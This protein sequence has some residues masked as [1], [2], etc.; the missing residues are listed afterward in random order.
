[1]NSELYNL[2]KAHKVNNIELHQINKTYIACVYSK[3]NASRK[4]GECKS[5]I[6]TNSMLSYEINGKESNSETGYSVF[7]KQL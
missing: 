4:T 7:M 1:M 6:E 2:F 5:F 3:H